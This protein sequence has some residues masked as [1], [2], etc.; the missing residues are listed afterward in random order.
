MKLFHTKSSISFN[1]NYRFYCYRRYWMRM[2]ML[3]KIYV[4]RWENAKNAVWLHLNKMK[5]VNE[6]HLH[7]MFYF[8]T[9]RLMLSKMLRRFKYSFCCLLVHAITCF[10][11]LTQTIH[12]L[13]C[14]FL[15]ENVNQHNRDILTLK[16]M[17]QHIVIRSI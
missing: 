7:K 16:H 1:K 11:S 3:V 5:Q 6:S 13:I 2:S 17:R 9:V 8:K 4:K 14:F 15:A 10:C 12:S